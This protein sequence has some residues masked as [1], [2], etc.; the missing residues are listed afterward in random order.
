MLGLKKILTVNN[1]ELWKKNQNC[2]KNGNVVW[3]GIMSLL[4]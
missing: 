4:M 3:T 2:Y 1:D